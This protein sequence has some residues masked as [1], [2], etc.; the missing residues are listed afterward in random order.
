MVYVLKR[1]CIYAYFF[2]GVVVKIPCK[3]HYYVWW[4]Y[5]KTHCKT[6]DADF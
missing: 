5:M 3:S 1:V 2:R 6:V 4:L